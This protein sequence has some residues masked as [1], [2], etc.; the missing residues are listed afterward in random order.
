MRVR[1]VV[2]CDG[3]EL[4]CHESAQA[5]LE[6]DDSVT[7]ALIEGIVLPAGWLERAW[8][9]RPHATTAHTLCPS[10]RSIL[11]ASKP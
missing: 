2:L 1:V 3:G 7:P 6:L 5:V 4:G 10:C 11:F 9:R 8:V